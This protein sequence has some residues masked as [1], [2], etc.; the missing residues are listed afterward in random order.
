MGLMVDKLTAQLG[1]QALSLWFAKAEI[2]QYPPS[3]LHVGI[4]ALR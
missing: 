1:N 3:S 4:L 2:Q